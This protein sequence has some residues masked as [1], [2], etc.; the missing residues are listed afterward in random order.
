M[1]GSSTPRLIDHQVDMRLRSRLA[2]LPCGF[3]GH[4][5]RQQNDRV[6][7]LAVRLPI[8][9]IEPR[10]HIAINVSLDAIHEHP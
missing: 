9:Q 5:I 3:F 1:T 8:T 4:P 6:A 10:L 7:Y 2:A